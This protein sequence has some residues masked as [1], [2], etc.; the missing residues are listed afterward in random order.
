MQNWLSEMLKQNKHSWFR[1]TLSFNTG[2]LPRSS[3]FPE[4]QSCS[5][6]SCR[7]RTASTESLSGSNLNSDIKLS[8]TLQ[9]VRREQSVFVISQFSSDHTP[10][11]CAQKCACLHLWPHLTKQQRTHC[12]TAAETHAQI[13]ETWSEKDN[14]LLTSG[15]GS[16][17]SL[18]SLLS[19][20]KIFCYKWNAG[21][22]NVT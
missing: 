6:W 9:V 8:S 1:L 17:L 16:I 18:H 21:F 5:E 3:S 12:I 20:C 15:E 7:G 2:L 11:H 14:D 19:Y 10:H 4:L 13:D 22:K